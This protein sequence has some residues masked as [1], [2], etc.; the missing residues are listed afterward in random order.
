MDI[1]VDVGKDWEHSTIQVGFTILLDTA[2]II[3]R[4]SSMILSTRSPTSA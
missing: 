3:I 4:R 2:T 1:V